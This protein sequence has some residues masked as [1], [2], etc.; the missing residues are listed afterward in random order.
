MLK[1]LLLASMCMF[2]LSACGGENDS[3]IN[4][5]SQVNNPKDLFQKLED[6]GKLPK[7]DRS[8]SI[9]G[10]DLNNNGIRDDVDQYIQ[11]TYLDPE[12][13][14]SVNQYAQNTQ[15]KLAVDPNDKLAVKRVSLESARA[16]TCVYDFYEDGLGPNGEIHED[17]FSVTYN[18]KK[19][20]KAY[21]DYDEAVSG[22]VL[23]IPTKDYCND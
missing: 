22:S 17:I 14:K 10:S 1:K 12:K 15:A 5:T 18:T 9:L 3:N 11:K 20:L 7:L 6:E 13:R 2:A 16:L 21:Y 23:S 19:R 4:K 8:D